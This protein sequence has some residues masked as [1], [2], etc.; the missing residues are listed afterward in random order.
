[1]RR[2]DAAL[3]AHEAAEAYR[4]MTEDELAELAASIKANGLRDPITVRIIGKERWIVDGRN[5]Q[6]ACEIAGVAPEYEEIE[7]PNADALRAFVLDRNERR[8]ITLGQKAMA[9]ARLT[10]PEKGGRGKKL[11]G[12]PES[13][14]ITKGHWANLVS[15][16]RMVMD[17][18][19]TLV[20]KVRD[21]FPLDEAYDLAMTAKRAP[22][23]DEALREKLAREA[24]DLMALV[25]DEKMNLREAV[26]AGDSGSAL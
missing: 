19:P 16:A 3:K 20:E 4:M 17:Y 13:L 9:H 7:F 23:T 8:N 6:K 2:N 11:S 22:E 21:G 18:A 25:Q 10:P 5:R 12:K 14:G 24:P 15:Q 26:A 1:M